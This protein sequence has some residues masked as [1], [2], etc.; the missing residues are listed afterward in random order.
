MIIGI[1]SADYA[2]SP[3]QSATQAAWQA[4]G[5]VRFGQWLPLWR[6]HH[7]V[8][9]GSLW[10]N[11]DHIDLKVHDPDGSERFVSP[12]VIYLQREVLDISGYLRIAR[13]SGQ[14]VVQDF[15]DWFWGVDPR[16][17]GFQMARQ[18]LPAIGA[19]LAASDLVTVSTPYLAER[20]GERFPNEIVVVPNYIDVSRFTPVDHGVDVPTIGWVGVTA[21]RSGDLPELRGV[22]NQF[23]GRARFQHSGAV[24]GQPRFADEVGLGADEVRCLPAKTFDEYPSII[25]FQIGL[26]PL[27]MSPFNEA[28]SDLK[29]LEY[30]ACGIPFVAAPSGPYVRLQDDWGRCVRLARKSADYVKGIKQL[31]DPDVRR[32][33]AAELLERV[34]ERDLRRG[35]GHYLELFDSLEARATSLHAGATPHCLPA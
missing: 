31:L 15:D 6:E 27:R 16:N 21:S 26:V 13:S 1:S 10:V 24:A 14:V 30:A 12:D 17:V 8:H 7:E 22:L 23:R 3:L 34:Q 32:A 19:N 4:A 2:I 35:V 29:G 11:G 20:I 28:K 5:W 18:V 9:V 25:D 33:C